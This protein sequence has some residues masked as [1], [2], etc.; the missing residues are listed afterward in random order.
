MR[1]IKCKGTYLHV[2]RIE[3]IIAIPI[4]SNIDSMNHNQEEST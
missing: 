4:P 1:C 2:E 3:V